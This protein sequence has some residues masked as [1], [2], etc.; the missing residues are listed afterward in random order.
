MQKKRFESVDGPEV[1]R[2]SGLHFIEKLALVF[3]LTRQCITSGGV[4]THMKKLKYFQNEKG[5]MRTF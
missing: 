3:P 4:K 2:S 1:R 5:K